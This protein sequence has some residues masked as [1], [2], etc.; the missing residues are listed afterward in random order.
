MQEFGAMSSRIKKLFCRG[1]FGNDRVAML[2]VR[3]LRCTSGCGDVGD[4]EKDEEAEDKKWVMISRRVDRSP[5]RN[6][7]FEH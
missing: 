3:D 2:G 5:N 4:E 6:P 7:R 1:G